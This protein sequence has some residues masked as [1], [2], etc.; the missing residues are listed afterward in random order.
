MLAIRNCSLRILLSIQ[1]VVL[2]KYIA[3]SIARKSVKRQSIVGICGAVM[4]DIRLILL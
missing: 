4:E 1:A 2:G 3:K